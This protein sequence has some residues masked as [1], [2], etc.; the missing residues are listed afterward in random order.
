[1]G[2]NR[3]IICKECGRETTT[4]SGRGLCSRCRPKFVTPEEK[5]RRHIIR[6]ERYQNNKEREQKRALDWYHANAEHANAV[7]QARRSTPEGKAVRNAALRKR[8]AKNPQKIKDAVLK[9]NKEHTKTRNL[10]IRRHEL[11]LLSVPGTHTAQ[12]W[13]DR[14]QEFNNCCGYCLRPLSDKATEDHMT[15]VSWGSIS[16][17]EIDNIIPA[18]GSCNSA[19][20][21]RNMLMHLLNQSRQT[22]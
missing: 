19:K 16:S 8:Y 11:A 22:I 1:M 6:L 17:N 20:G 9:W 10:R 7:Q 4:K 13:Q 5:E 18:C 14:L 15:P 2:R 3:T 21:G 12:E